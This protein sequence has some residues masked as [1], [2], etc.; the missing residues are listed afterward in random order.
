MWRDTAQEK[1]QKIKKFPLPISQEL[2]LALIEK[3][4]S[5]IKQ[6]RAEIL[7]LR[8]YPI[9]EPWRSH[10]M[11]Q[12]VTH[13]I[14]GEC[15]FFVHP[16]IEEDIRPLIL[17]ERDILPG[18]LT[19]EIYDSRMDRLKRQSALAIVELKARYDTYSKR[20]KVFEQ[21]EYYSRHNVLLI[22]Y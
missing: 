15:I 9:P 18:G 1:I 8:T 19:R 5:L 11:R 7:K 22:A 3:Y 6:P 10:C 21:L 13:L 2:A 17:S 20:P 16:G 12:E 14:K 4:E